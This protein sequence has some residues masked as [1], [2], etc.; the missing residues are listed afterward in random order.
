MSREPPAVHNMV[1]LVGRDAE[2]RSLFQ[3]AQR[4]RPE[5][6]GIAVV[7]GAPGMG[8]TALLRRFAD[9]LAERTDHLVLTVSAEC[10][11]PLALYGRFAAAL[12]QRLLTALV[13]AAAER[14]VTVVIDD[15]HRADT[16]SALA[17]GFVTRRLYAHRVLLVLAVPQAEDTH[18]NQLTQSSTD[19]VSSAAERL[20][21]PAFRCRNGRQ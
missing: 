15:V 12:R 8:K 14:P 19:S 9:T 2:L 13:T 3:H 4:P 10:A 5:G 17:L 16:A 1:G 21:R 11:E 7:S 6:P 18:P 20:G